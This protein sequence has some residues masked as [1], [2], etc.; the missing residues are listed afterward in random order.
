M[1]GITIRPSQLTIARIA[2]AGSVALDIVWLLACESKRDH[3]AAARFP[4]LLAGQRQAVEE[5]ED[6]EHRKASPKGDEHHPM[7]RRDTRGQRCT[8]EKDCKNA[9][10]AQLDLD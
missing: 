7:A 1:I 6:I 2:C 3:D 5:R 4:G 8:K 9:K 10:L